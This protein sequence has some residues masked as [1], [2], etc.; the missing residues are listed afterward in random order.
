VARNIK[1]VVLKTNN[2]AIIK[3]RKVKFKEEAR[4]WVENGYEPILFN[5]DTLIT[6][7]PNPESGRTHI[8]HRAAMV[9]AFDCKESLEEIEKLI[10]QSICK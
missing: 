9:D 10:K 8:R 3:L 6:A 5:T 1:I 7:I 4:K 2:M